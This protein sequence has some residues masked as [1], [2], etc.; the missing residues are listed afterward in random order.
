MAKTKPTSVSVDEYIDKLDKEEL[1]DDCR[2]LIK[3]MSKITG[4]PPVMW[5]PSIIGFG[6]YHYKY[7]SGHEGDSCLAGFAA[8]KTN[9]VVYAYH[10]GKL[11]EKLGKHKAT[12]GCIY[13][14]CL[15]DVDMKILERIVKASVATLRKK[16]P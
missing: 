4:A 13:I 7:T 3:M 8:R 15:A 6:S 12:G 1:R 2:V 5:G 16:Y 10:D 14:K 9:I 11:I